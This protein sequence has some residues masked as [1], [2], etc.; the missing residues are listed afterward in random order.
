MSGFESSGCAY[1]A[2][3]ADH[4]IAARENFITAL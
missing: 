2:A 1:V 4:A 3:K